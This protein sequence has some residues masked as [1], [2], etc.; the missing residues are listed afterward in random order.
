[1]TNVKVY[2][3]VIMATGIIDKQNGTEGVF[4]GQSRMVLRCTPVPIH[5][6]P[7]ENVMLGGRGLTTLM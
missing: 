7:I 3:S 4:C 1:M 5:T 2:R 6:V